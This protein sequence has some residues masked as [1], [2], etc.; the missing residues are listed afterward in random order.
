MRHKQ[1]GAGY[2]ARGSYVGSDGQEYIIEYTHESP[3]LVSYSV[4]L[5]EKE[6]ESYS[7]LREAAKSEFLS[8]LREVRD[9]ALSKRKKA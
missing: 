8:A 6:V 5:N 9:F 2:S 3:N 1:S 7:N 4:S